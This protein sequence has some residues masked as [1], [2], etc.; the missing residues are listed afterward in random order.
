M[1]GIHLAGP[2]LTPET[3]REGLYHLPPIKPGPLGL[4]TIVTYGDHGFW[5]GTDPAGLDNAG[6]LYWDPEATGPDETG[7]EGKGMYR[8]VDGGKRYTHGKWPTTPMKLFDPEGTVTIYEAGQIP[9]RAEAGRHSEA[10][11]RSRQQVA[12][13]RSSKF[14]RRSGGSRVRVRRRQPSS[15]APRCPRR[16]RPRRSRRGDRSSSRAARP[17][18]DRASCRRRSRPARCATSACRSAGRDPRSR[19]SD[20]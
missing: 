4:N 12:D 18:R 20:R 8:L 3:F 7:A 9:R 17:R 6:I 16:P 13:Q 2:K 10:R 11:R 5:D 1:T 14:R 19:G 15:R